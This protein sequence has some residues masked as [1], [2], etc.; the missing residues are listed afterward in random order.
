MNGWQRLWVVVFVIVGLLLMVVGEKLVPSKE[1]IAMKFDKPL[2]QERR[3]LAE[4]KS[5]RFDTDAF[6]QDFFGGNALQDTEARIR[7]LETR[8]QSELDS[9]WTDQLKLRSVFVG[10]WFVFGLILYAIGA[11]VGWVYRGF[12]PKAV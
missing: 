1:T 9:L 11:T 7:D 4:L 12:R 5:K 2:E 3:F 6:S 8:R 10:V